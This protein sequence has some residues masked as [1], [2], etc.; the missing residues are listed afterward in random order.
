M[1]K[2]L[3]ATAATLTLMASSTAFAQSAAPTAPADPANP[4]IQ[5][6]AEMAPST[7]P[8][9]DVTVQGDAA[10]PGGIADMSAEELVGRDVI[11]PEGNSVGEI[12]DLMLDSSQK[13]THV[14]V[15][16]GG[17]LGIGERTVAIEL[18]QL[19]VDTSNDDHDLVTRMTKEQLE[20][21]PAYEKVDGAWR[22]AQ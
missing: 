5:A 9:T 21:L 15:G 18:N 19:S 8:S 2:T 4:V 17:F 13:I 22:L 10:M 20:A 7:A 11:D 14:L 1:R 6:P 3:L 12:A 16:V